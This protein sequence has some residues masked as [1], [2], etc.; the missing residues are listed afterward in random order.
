MR[1]KNNKTTDTGW[2]WLQRDTQRCTGRKKHHFKTES[3]GKQRAYGRGIK[4]P[5]TFWKSCLHMTD[6]MTETPSESQQTHGCQ[7]TSEGSGI[8]REE[9][10]L[11][12]GLRIQRTSQQL[13]PQTD[14]PPPGSICAPFTPVPHTC[15]CPDDQ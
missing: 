8:S 4:A 2:K 5:R 3:K 10:L 13:Q 1:P 14:N 6:F 7:L 9:N 12:E 11:T 15:T